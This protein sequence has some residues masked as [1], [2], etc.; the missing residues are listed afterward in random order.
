MTIGALPGPGRGRRVHGPSA[1]AGDTRRFLILTKTLAVT[2]FKLRF[3][4]S[5]F[6]YLWQLMRPLMLFGVLYVV[7]TQFVE[8]SDQEFF[9]VSL[10]LAIVLYTFFALSLIHI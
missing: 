10:L 9:A 3:F 1:L 8:V 6:G 7:F 5:V 4:G 2:E